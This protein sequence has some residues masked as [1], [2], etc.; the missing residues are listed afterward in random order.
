MITRSDHG[1]RTGRDNAELSP[2]IA[3]SSAV[4]QFGFF[5]MVSQGWVGVVADPPTLVEPPRGPKTMHVHVTVTAHAA[6]TGVRVPVV[7]SSVFVVDVGF[8]LVAPLHISLL[9]P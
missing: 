4:V 3:R 1:A 5:Y 8:V 9:A 2:Y 6:I 7:S